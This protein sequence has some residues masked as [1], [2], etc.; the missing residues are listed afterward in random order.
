MN[1]VFKSSFKLLVPT[2]CVIVIELG[3]I[4]LTCSFPQLGNV[5]SLSVL[6]SI[7][8][9]SIFEFGLIG[10]GSIGGSSFPAFGSIGGSSFPAFESIGG[11]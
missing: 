4:N 6:F 9:G 5:L 2:S 11:F 1:Y 8:Y 3:E 7:G 10:G